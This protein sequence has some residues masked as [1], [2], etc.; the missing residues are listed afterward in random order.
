MTD[1]IGLVFWKDT[2]PA[3]QKEDEWDVGPHEQ[4]GGQLG[5]PSTWPEASTPRHPSTPPRGLKV[6]RAFSGYIPSP[7]KCRGS[8]QWIK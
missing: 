4:Q 5:T 1:M 2:G 7:L 8:G 3:V 6:I